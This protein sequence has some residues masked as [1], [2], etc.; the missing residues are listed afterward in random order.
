MLLSG[1]A[2]AS[3][4]T[5]EYSQWALVVL[6][7]HC[8]RRQTV[9]LRAGLLL[10]GDRLLDFD[11]VRLPLERSQHLQPSMAARCAAKSHTRDTIRP[12][13]RR[14]SASRIALRHAPL[15]INER[16]AAR[17]VG[18]GVRSSEGRSACCGESPPEPTEDAEE[19]RNATKGPKRC[20]TGTGP[21]GL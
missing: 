10:S 11:F 17:P 6:T 14:A 20:G 18:L 5:R 2:S 21:V 3:R 9:L 12:G 7:E 1:G 15:P 8:N 16:S 4:G 19:R 13:A